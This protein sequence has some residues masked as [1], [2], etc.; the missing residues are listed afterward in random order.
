MQN[1]IM[2][3]SQ[4]RIR[5]MQRYDEKPHKACKTGS[6]SC[7]DMMKN[8]TKHAKPDQDHAKPA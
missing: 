3:I 5:I 8:R 6:G 4:N 2:Q 7:K 1:W